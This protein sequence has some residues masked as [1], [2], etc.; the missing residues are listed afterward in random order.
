MT[1]VSLSLKEEMLR[2]FDVSARAKGYG[3]RSEAFREAL[4]EFI[5]S[6]EWRLSGGANTVVLSILYSKDMPR[7]DLTTLQ[8][9]YGEIRT[10]LHTHLDEVNCLEVVV[11]GGE[12][13]RLRELID[14]VRKIKGV[15]QIKFI[16]TV[17][18]V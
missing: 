1:I 5:S 9:R 15:K 10:M 16:S 18:N 8:H 4:R 13:A 14:R 11:A 17:A 7:A 3:T 2:R 6:T 12:N